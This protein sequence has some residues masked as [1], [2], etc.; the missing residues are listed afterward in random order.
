MFN[1]KGKTL[2]NPGMATSWLFFAPGAYFFISIVYTQHLATNTDYVIG[3]GLGLVMNIVGVFK[4]IQWLA[5][6]HTSYI[7]SERHML[8]QGRRKGN[9]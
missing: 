3:I 2:Y 4:L 7:F 9:A 1:I 6:E 5:D 8:P